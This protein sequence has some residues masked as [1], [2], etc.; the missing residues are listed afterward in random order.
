MYLVRFQPDFSNNALNTFSIFFLLPGEYSQNE[1]SS[2]CHSSTVLDTTKTVTKKAA[3]EA[4]SAIL[5]NKNDNQDVISDSGEA[6]T[7]V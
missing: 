1:K 5:P 2:K 6:P 3:I 7:K 4:V